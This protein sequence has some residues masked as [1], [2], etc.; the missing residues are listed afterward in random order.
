[1]TYCHL[2]HDTHCG[3]IFCTFHKGLF[4]FSFYIVWLVNGWFYD[5]RFWKIFLLFYPL[6][7]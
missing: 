2:G 7:L 4:Y 5:I 3:C 6:M 1:M